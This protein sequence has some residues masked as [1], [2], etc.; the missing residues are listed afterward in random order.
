MSSS[1]SVSRR[2]PLAAA[3]APLVVLAC[4]I[5]GPA[6]LAA[7]QP[8]SHDTSRTRADTAMTDTVGHAAR[9]APVTIT[10][11]PV[12]GTEPQTSVTITPHVLDIT[13]ST[14]P[15]DLLRQAAGV[16]VHLQGQGPGFA[17][18]ASI[19]GFSS[20]HSTDIALWIDGV[21]I[22]EP[23][24]G[25]AEGY[26]DW[27]LIF[28]KAVDAVDVIEGPTSA[29]YGNFALAGVVDVR[30]LDRM[31]GTK[32]WLSGGSYG[33]LDA[34]VMTGFDHG[35]TGGGVFGVRWQHDDGWRPNS[36]FD[37]QQGHFRVVHDLSSSTRI[38]AGV[39]LYGS[40]WDSP[41][42]INDSEFVARDYGIVSNPTDG[43][44][45]YRAQERVGLRV[46][47]GSMLWR[48]TLYSTQGNWHFW[49]TVPPNGG[50]FEGSGSQTEEEDNRL[51]VGGT[52]ALT[53]SLPIGELT[54][55][56]EGRWDRSH[57]QNWFATDRERDSAAELVHAAQ[58]SGAVFVQSSL[59]PAD[60]LHLSIG[61]RYDLLRTASTPDGDASTSDSHGIFSPKLGALVDVWHGIGVYGNV[62]RGFRSTD[63]VIGDP[64]LPLITEWAYESGVKLAR[65]TAGASLSYFWIDVSNEQTFNPL[66]AGSFSG[67][68]SRRTGVEIAA[69][70]QV[71]PAVA[72]STN[73]T[74]TNARYRNTT[75]QDPLDPDAVDTLSGLRIYNT[76]QYVGTASVDIA[77]PAS[78]WR[79]RVSTNV[80]G[81]Y[82]PFEEPGVVLPSYG[83]VHVS[84]SY[85]I[86]SAQLEVGI[87]NLLDKAYAELVAGQPSDDNTRI[88]S[89]V[90][91]GQPRSVYATVRYSF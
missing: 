89:L 3:L 37:V 4:A 54:V 18:D 90:S 2:S 1:P 20:D 81:P 13:P 56:G 70:A 85:D 88:V 14:S 64:T 59:T 7:Q 6:R 5:G 65:G 78:P 84:G 16:E 86:G 87:R 47:S 33:N 8:A 34:T 40:Q 82:S 30:T 77:P 25:H 45:K 29:L 31:Q 17:S 50:R 36:R 35:P 57:Y 42:F 21:P 62:S 76:A 72:L 61:G 49:L 67:G 38:D 26:N 66:T 46:L 19:R 58:T 60:R 32:A 51:G 71:V 44:S 41:G 52:T 63:G 22:N 75:E 27:G 68:A 23:V 12:T 73:W 9:L 15:W 48:T 80:V 11:T 53:W 24:N 43:G 55:G 28:P 79:I 91:P 69:H 83:L 74:F 39:E 10:A